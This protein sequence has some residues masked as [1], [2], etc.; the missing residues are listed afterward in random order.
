MNQHVFKKQVIAVCLRFAT[1]K[2]EGEGSADCRNKAK[3][4]CE[5]QTAFTVFGFTVAGKHG[6]SGLLRCSLQPLSSSLTAPPTLL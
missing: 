4:I 1:G 6:T 3:N 2:A 5:S